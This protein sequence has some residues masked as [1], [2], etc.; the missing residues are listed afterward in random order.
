MHPDK[1]VCFVG[2]G[3]MGCFNA[4][5]AASGGY[6]CVIHDVSQETLD[7]VP[8]NL[9]DMSERFTRS[10]LLKSPTT[11]SAADRIST[12]TDLEEAVD[13]AW[14]VS[15]SVFE[16][17]DLKRQVF[18]QLDA[19]CPS[20]VLLTTNS[21]VLPVSEIADSV[22]YKQRFSALHSHLGSSLF[23]ILGTS[24]T[25][26]DTTSVLR[27]YVLSLGG[28]PLIL[29]KENP[30]YVFNAM[31]GPI[32]TRALLL[33]IDGLATI[34]ETDRAWMNRTSSP[35]G[36][37]GLMDLFGLNLIYD[38]WYHRPERP[39]ETERRLKI[40][41]F[42]SPLVGRG[43]LGVKTGKGFYE[44]PNPAYAEEGFMHDLPATNWA[45]FYLTSAWLQNAVMLAINGI[46]DVR[47]ID[48]AWLAATGQSLGPFGMIDDLGLE[49]TLILFG[50]T[51][52]LT[53]P[54]CPERLAE[55]LMTQLSVGKVGISGGH[56][57]Y[58]YPN[59][60]YQ[61]P[62]FVRGSV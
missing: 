39:E 44:Y 23:D 43:Q 10:G 57:F 47:D 28:V 29:K 11:A 34:H 26:S 25:S 52:P 38:S 60:A 17:L 19:L 59:P 50:T 16:S 2:G 36:P 40:R 8:E 53:R 15:E 7:R 22:Q 58:D 18:A 33:V 24:Q 49:R 46:A 14:L 32:L 56:G 1:H 6:Q 51:G 41:A 45:D 27:D 48:R 5:L 42:L 54:E 35:L 13:G 4:L 12:T 55:F 62:G 21:S 30:G 37:F 9:T 20:E 31:F 61:D 3:T